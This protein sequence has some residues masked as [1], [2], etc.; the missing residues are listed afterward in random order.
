[1]FFVHFGLL[2]AYVLPYIGKVLALTAAGHVNRMLGHASD[3]IPHSWT[4]NIEEV[5]AIGVLIGL[6]KGWLVPTMGAVLL[7][8]NGLRALLTIRIGQLRDAEERSGITPTL[9]EYMGTQG[10]RD[11]GGGRI[12]IELFKG[13]IRWWLQGQ[14]NRIG[15]G[16]SDF[17]AGLE[18]LGLWRLHLLLRVLFLIVIVYF[19]CHTV[20]WAATTTVPIVRV[21]SP[22]QPAAGATP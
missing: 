17:Y 18:A 5:S 22:A 12:A 6:E 13:F 10:L 14:F 19:L 3:R 1:M 20:Y 2:L 15:R 7:V 9:A 11:E 21:E 16:W 4:A 8:Y